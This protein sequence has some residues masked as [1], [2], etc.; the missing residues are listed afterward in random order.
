MSHLPSSQRGV[1]TDASK[2]S[3]RLTEDWHLEPRPNA[4]FSTRFKARVGG[5]SAKHDGKVTSRVRSHSQLRRLGG[6][7]PTFSWSLPSPCQFPAICKY[8]V[9]PKVHVRYSRHRDERIT[10]G[11]KPA[12]LRFEL[13]GCTHS[14][15]ASVLTALCIEYSAAPWVPCC[16]TD[17]RNPSLAQRLNSDSIIKV[18]C[19]W[20]ALIWRTPLFPLV[21][22]LIS[23]SF[24]FLFCLLIMSTIR[25]SIW[26]GSHEFLCGSGYYFHSS[27]FWEHLDR[28]KW[29]LAESTHMWCFWI[30]KKA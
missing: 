12:G 18:L 7:S 8:R 13:W 19:W 22:T 14:F 29:F 16:I 6:N 17:S 11:T 5:E 30:L 24:H 1:S 3:Q 23:L 15:R 20:I 27:S 26:G 10:D 9:T 28:K 25:V 4:T 2:F 21:T